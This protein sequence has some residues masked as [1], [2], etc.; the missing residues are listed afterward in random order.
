MLVTDFITICSPK[1][2]CFWSRYLE[3]PL[4]ISGETGYFWTFKEIWAIMQG[5]KSEDLFVEIKPIVTSFSK[6]F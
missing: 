2:P 1:Q 6:I 4:D 5:L 3:K